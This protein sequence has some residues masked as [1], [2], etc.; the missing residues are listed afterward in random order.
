MPGY[1][2]IYDDRLTVQLGH[3]S[4]AERIISAKLHPG[5]IALSYGRQF[6]VVNPRPK[7]KIFLREIQDNPPDPKRLFVEYMAHLQALVQ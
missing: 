4:V 3:L 5:V 6:E 7:T 1:T 2:T